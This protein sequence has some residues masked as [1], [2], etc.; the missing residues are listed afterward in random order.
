MYLKKHLTFHLFLKISFTT[1]S[2]KYMPTA[3]TNPAQCFAFN[4]SN[5]RHYLGNETKPTP[6]PGVPSPHVLFQYA[7]ACKCLAARENDQGI[8][9][10]LQNGRKCK[11]IE[12]H[13][14]Q[15]EY[16]RLMQLQFALNLP[17]ILQPQWKAPVWKLWFQNPLPVWKS[18]QAPHSAPERPEILQQTRA[19]QARTSTHLSTTNRIGMFSHMLLCFQDDFHIALKNCLTAHKC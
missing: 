1:R 19:Q 11:K 10:P 7:K 17:T 8:W 18:L 12:W 16:P 14:K 3:N 5:M 6:L 15:F 4:S 9:S 13:R 2:I